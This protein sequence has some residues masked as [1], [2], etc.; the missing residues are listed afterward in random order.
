MSFK[1]CLMD[2]FR[3]SEPCADEIVSRLRPFS[4]DSQFNQA[5]AQLIEKSNQLNLPFLEGFVPQKP[6][7][8]DAV[9]V[10]P[11]THEVLFESPFIRILYTELQPGDKVVPHIHQWD[12]LLFIISGSTFAMES[13]DTCEQESWPCGVYELS[14]DMTPAGF[15]NLGSSPYIALNIEIKKC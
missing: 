15:V 6:V 1:E 8:E 10:A 4:G 2:A 11:E 5:L 13:G 14:G 12:S 9:T 7:S 3:V